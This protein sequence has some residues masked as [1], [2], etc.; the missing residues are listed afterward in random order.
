[1]WMQHYLNCDLVT[2]E[3]I[4]VY[5][6]GNKNNDMIDIDGCRNVVI[7]GCVGDSD[8]DGI[9]LK[10][11]A[12]A[13]TENVV[14]SDCIVSSFCNAIKM[15]TESLG[16]F[17]NIAVSNCLIRPSSEPEQIYGRREGL[18]GIALEIVD[19]G[20]MDGV[21]ISNVSIHGSTA[22]IFIRLGDRGRTPRPGLAKSP[23]GELKNVSIS[24]IV[25]RQAGAV[26]C[27]ISG[28]PG[29]RIE[30]VTMSNIQ[31]QFV[32]GVDSTLFTADVPEHEAK[33]PECTMFGVLPA[34]GFYA[35]HV[36]GLTLRDINLFYENDDHRPAL[37]L[38]DVTD[39]HIDHLKAPGDLAAA[40]I[41]L[42]NVCDAMIS[43]CRPTAR[44]AFINLKK[45][46]RGV[47][48]FANDFNR[49]SHAVLVS[50][51]SSVENI[52]TDFRSDTR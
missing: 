25:A 29:S 52:V 12:L 48:I 40:T 35:R 24:N 5:N 19:G 46:C 43:G 9:T 33:Y 18:A 51:S 2:I 49:V 13:P 7:H 50:D 47:S 8:D 17:K 30:N 36:K 45:N 15:G 10:S 1:M 41:V 11:T 21:A 32:G 23:V 20:V 37:M 39:L 27:A 14:I 26:G 31:L 44:E 34:F 3:N 22:P 38:D 4:T 6:H 42:Q 28:V 16:G